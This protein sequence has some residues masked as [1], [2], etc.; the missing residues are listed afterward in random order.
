MQRVSIVIPTLNSERYLT[1]TLASIAAQEGDFALDVHIQD[2]GSADATLAIAERWKA[3]VETGVALI[4]CK[5]IAVSIASAPDSGMYQAIDRGF[6]RL[7][8]DQSGAMTWINSDDLLAPGAV[9]TALEIF[10]TFPEVQ[11]LGG[12][13]ALLEE[14]GKIARLEM[15]MLYRRRRLEAGLYDG[16]QDSFLTQEG[17]F[18]R[19][20]LWTVSG[21]LDTSFRLA[22]DWDLWRRFARHAGYAT[23]DTVLGLHRRRRGQLSEDLASYSAEVERH[24]GKRSAGAAPETSLVLSYDRVDRR[25]RRVGP[26]RLLLLALS[27]FAFR[28]AHLRRTAITRR[29]RR[30]LTR[31]S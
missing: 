18:W 20:E 30:L 7:P 2:G 31:R 6:A 21:G 15:P 4:S 25:W 8:I 28:L 29:L 27:R 5:G 1:A 13:T 11:W 12:R 24:R 22:G 10:A 26:F 3:A 9:A 14:D 23:V 19:P 17:V 16:Q